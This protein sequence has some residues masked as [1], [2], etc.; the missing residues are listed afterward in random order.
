MAWMGHFIKFNYAN[1]FMRRL[2]QRITHDGYS[3]WLFIL[4]A[5]ILVSLFGLPILALSLR[6]I[7][8]NFFDYVLS[9]QALSALRLSLITSLITV[10]ITIFLG[11]PL[12]YIL[13]RWKFPSKPYLGFD[14]N[15]QRARI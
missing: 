14:G 5:S 6:A 12:A 10:G 2:F 4:P 8:V 11:T 7:D 13:A 15:F 9:E 1:F 3:S